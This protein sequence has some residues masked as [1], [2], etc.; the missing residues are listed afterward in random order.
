M[1][2][3]LCTVLMLALMLP[4]CV[5]AEET[6][7]ARAVFDMLQA[8]DY[9]SVYALFDQI[10]RN[11]M[12]ENDLR[13]AFSDLEAAFGKVTA[14]GEE[15]TAGPLP[16]RNTFLPVHY[17]KASF[18]LEVIWQENRIV[19]LYFT[20]L[21]DETPGQEDLPEGITGK[22]IQVGDPALEGLLTLPAVISN[23]V[24]AVVLVHGSGPSDRD[25][26]M[27]QT[28]PF[29][30]LAYGLAGQ[31][32]A[33]L[34]YDKR[35]YVY[36]D[37]YTR[38]DLITFTVKEETINDAV[39]AAQILR[40]D[41]RVDPERIYLVGHSMGAMLA[42]RIAVENPGLFAGIILLSGTP[43]TL[44]DIV[45]SQNQ[46]LV[47]AMSPLEK[48]LGNMQMAGLRQS[49]Q[50]VL[51]STEEEAKGKMLFGQPAY[52]FWEMAQYDTAEILKTLDIPALI[53]NGGADFQVT[54]A[55][56]IDA[57]RAADLPESVQISYYP[58]LNHLLMHPEAPDSMRGTAKEYDIPCH[59][60]EEII[61]EVSAFI[62]N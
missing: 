54:D 10:M 22:S 2:R 6:Y 21:K 50:N 62:L 27:G 14:V 12:T 55:D 33:V 57:W 17:E 29:R 56:G 16:Y 38:E 48:I 44:A 45:L 4:V 26:N 59:V 40:T 19:G 42:P 43:K 8:G 35:T 13:K 9:A 15:E 37:S 46:A 11:A 30:D 39:A 51:N 20:L 24:P 28:K 41:P 49:W 34:R 7:T 3:I 18:S 47:D 32:I 36:G 52:Y 53:I 60:S 61:E 23:P 1:K 25:E 5:T 31:G 58:E